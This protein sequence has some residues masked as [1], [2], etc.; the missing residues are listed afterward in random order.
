MASGMSAF[1]S[2]PPPMRANPTTTAIATHAYPTVFMDS[3]FE[4]ERTPAN[5]RASGPGPQ[6]LADRREQDTLHPRSDVGRGGAGLVPALFVSV[7][8][9]AVPWTVAAVG[10]Q[11]H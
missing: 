3:S 8:G 2:W 5:S 9:A 4:N 1:G 7:G 6:E 11:A 10:P